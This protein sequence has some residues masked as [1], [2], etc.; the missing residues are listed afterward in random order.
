MDYSG[1][2]LR[3]PEPRKREKARLRR[4]AKRVIETV[5]PQ[6]VARDGYCRARDI[7]M[8]ACRGASEWAHFGDHRRA[9]TRG[10]PPEERHTTA[11][12]L[13]FCVGHHD[14]YD[15]GRMA[16]AATTDRECDGPLRFEKD[17]VVH[18]EAE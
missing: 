6:V 1:L 7:G 9:R 16:V 5:R 4:R 18:T 11:G 2:P 13:M 10:K 15:E 12:S 14:D 17:G 8:G 3:K